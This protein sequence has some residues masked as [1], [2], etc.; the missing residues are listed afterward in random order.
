MSRGRI[1]APLLAILALALGA[2]AVTD[3]AVLGVAAKRKPAH[4]KSKP[5]AA[6]GLKA[7]RLLTPASGV[8]VEAMPTL[9]WSAVKGAVEYEW[10]VSAESSFR[11]QII[12]RGVGQGTPR[13]T[14]LAATLIGAQTDGTYYWR[15]RGVT[16]S[17]KAGS[18]VERAHV[19][20][21]LDA[22]RHVARAF[23]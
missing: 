16:K 11:S 5:K 23:K 17:G 12:Q 4:H 6:N 10:Q 15:V 2:V 7:P 14:N 8:F 22:D 13:T 18:L 21:A 20:E 1:Y 3:A 19:R 9:T